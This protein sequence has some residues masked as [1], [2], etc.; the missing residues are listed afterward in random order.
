M[1]QRRLFAKGGWMLVQNLAGKVRMFW[2]PITHL[3][4]VAAKPQGQDIIRVADKY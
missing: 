1:P 4:K 2:H 3:W